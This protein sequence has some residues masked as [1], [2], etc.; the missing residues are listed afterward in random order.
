M[1]NFLDRIRNSIKAFNLEV[2][3]ESY[4][5]FIYSFLGNNTISNNTQDD[6]FIK[7]GYAYN[8]TI[9]SI[10]NLIAKSA[11]TVPFQIYNKLDQGALKEYKALTGNGLNTES[12]I[13]S[14]LIRKEALMEVENTALDKLLDRPN[15]AQSWSV[16]LEELIGFGKLTGNRYVYGIYP[17]GGE[18]KEIVYQLYNLL[19]K[20]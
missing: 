20:V 12:I 4:N 10:I 6:D 7:K 18:N 19:L 5:R 1:P 11:I 16:F 2:T 9:Y 8:P 14:K 15:P 3:N 13:K 17:D